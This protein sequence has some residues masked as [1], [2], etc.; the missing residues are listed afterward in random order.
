MTTAGTLAGHGGAPPAAPP[1]PVLQHREV[2]VARVG[3]RLLRV[4]W[5]PCS[6]WQPWSVLAAAR[7]RPQARPL[8]H[9]DRAVGGSMQPTFSPGDVIIVTPEPVTA[10]R[11]GQVISYQIPIGDHHVESHRVVR[12]VERGPHPVIITRGDNNAEADPWRAQL[13]SGTAWQERLVIPG[14]GRVII[15]MR[16]PLLQ[17]I[18]VL[19]IPILLAVWWLVGIW[20]PRRRRRHRHDSAAADRD[21]GAAGGDRKFGRRGHR[22]PRYPSPAPGRQQA[23]SS[24]PAT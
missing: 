2:W 7:C 10:V 23:G 18:C 9:G 14:V 1:A 3:L 4:P 24:R 22:R 19:V 21:A 11:P 6:R 8:P 15:W 5:R 13:T 20:R 12:V 16:Q 17:R